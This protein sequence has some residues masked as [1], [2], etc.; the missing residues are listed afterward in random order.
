[1]KLMAY[2]IEINTIVYVIETLG[3]VIKTLKYLHNQIQ[4]LLITIQI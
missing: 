3:N 4:R 1:M 2:I